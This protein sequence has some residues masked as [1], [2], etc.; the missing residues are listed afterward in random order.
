MGRGAGRAGGLSHAWE[1]V[2]AEHVAP[3]PAR[4]FVQRR[5]WREERPVL[6]RETREM[7]HKVITR[8]R[9]CIRGGISM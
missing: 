9:V 5:T 4:T 1:P 7:L 6:K 8:V 3:G 2:S